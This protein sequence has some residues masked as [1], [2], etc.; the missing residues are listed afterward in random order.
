MWRCSV[1]SRCVQGLL[2]VWSP[3]RSCFRNCLGSADVRGLPATGDMKSLLLARRWSVDV[4][5]VAYCCLL[6]TICWPTGG[7]IVHCSSSELVNRFCCSHSIS[8]WSLFSWCPQWLSLF[9][10]L[11]VMSWVLFWDLRMNKASFSLIRHCDCFYSF[12]CSL[13][14]LY[15]HTCY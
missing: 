7:V 5:L 12:S 1:W 8:W 14:G 13:I 9:E 3:I 11:R 2:L 10:P 6:E 4:R 15:R